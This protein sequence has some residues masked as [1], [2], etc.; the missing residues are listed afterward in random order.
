MNAI[1]EYL[2]TF[3]D[4]VEPIEFYRDIFPEGE[5]QEKGVY[6]KG[7]YNG[8]LVS[9]T[10]EKKK[11]GKSPLIKRYT[12]TDD[13]EVIDQVSK[14]DD[15]CL[16]S[17]ISY[18]GKNRSAENARFIYA[19]AVDLDRIRVE[20]GSPVGLRSLLERHV[21]LVGRIPKPTYIVSSGSGVHL[22]Y[23]LDHPIRLYENTSKQLQQFKYDFTELIWHDTICD[24]KSKKEIQQEG[25]YQGFRVPGT[26]T[27]KGE[28]ARV[29]LIGERVSMDHL[30]SFVKE[31]H[32]VTEFTE[33]KGITLSEAKDRYPE[34]YERRIVR[35]EERGVWHVS[36][37]LYEWWKRQILSGATV[38][39]RY[40]CIMLLAIYAKKCSF[41][42]A[43]HNPEP[44]TQEELE[45]DAFEIMDHMESLTV[46]EDNHFT[47]DDVLKAILSFDDKWIVY[48][49]KSA[50]F[51][52][53]ISIP[54]NKR[55]KR[56]LKRDDGTAFK[57]ARAIQE[58]YDP[59]GEW[60][61]KNG[62]PSKKDLVTD[63]ILKHPGGKKA[64]CIRDTGLS[65]PTVYKYWKE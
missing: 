49:R 39:H 23:L 4:E 56:P 34:W 24:I 46:S 19:I 7:R 51:K 62:R 11:D 32:R 53:G 31:D 20:K 55:R 13:L 1:T 50:E 44:V 43:K 37:N 45:R 60:R 10:K 59:D 33:K 35:K 57:A 27:K 47:T 41:Y 18:A 14:T 16:M 58:I 42:D 38:G 6:Q 52:S 2:Q 28:R 21:E 29:F 3:Y 25:I 63:W 9:V 30:N 36:R 40:N 5:L 22:Y 48:S 26:I 15:F 54:A 61:N 17:P 65:K 12:V 8:I 64:D